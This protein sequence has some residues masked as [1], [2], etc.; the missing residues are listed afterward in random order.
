MSQQGLLSNRV[1]RRRNPRLTNQGFTLIELLVV[2]GILSVMA[3]IALNDVTGTVGQQ[4]FDQTVYKMKNIRRAIL[5]K[6]KIVNGELVLE[7]FVADMGR[8]PNNLSELLNQQYC[9]NF[10]YKNKV[11]CEDGSLGNSEWVV[12][13][14]YAFKEGFCSDFLY[15][16]KT[17]CE[18]AT[19][20]GIWTTVPKMQW[21]WRGPYINVF[22]DLGGNRTYRDGW[23]NK[24]DDS[25]PNSGWIFTVVDV[26]ERDTDG[27]GALDAGDGIFDQL[28]FRSKGQNNVNDVFNTA[29]NK[30]QDDI[31]EETLTVHE[32]PYPPHKN[33]NEA[34]LVE[35]ADFQLNI[36]SKVVVITIKN[37]TTSIKEISGLTSNQG[38]CVGLYSI[39]NGVSVFI[40]SKVKVIPRAPDLS[41]GDPTLLTVLEPAGDA[42]GKDSLELRFE[43]EKQYIPAGKI[44]L[45]DLR[46][47]LVGG[48]DCNSE[49]TFATNV[50]SVFQYKTL[51]P[52][53]TLVNDVLATF[54]L[55]IN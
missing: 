22:A 52:R 35:R 6:D 18:N 30:Y 9:R 42:D 44:A 10:K 11:D 39:K 21:G 45:T 32:R 23:G 54:E 27:D 25:D 37:N 13:P 46:E 2:I 1:M 3:T 16:T 53:T 26:L 29:E 33:N 5:G 15:S 8:L 55:E 24:S 36:E 41:V 31:P 38:L 4:S 40:P 50:G 19:P 14:S 43:F 7:G 28:E 12:L 49:S 20:A 17:T 48:T 51:L 47:Q 34:L